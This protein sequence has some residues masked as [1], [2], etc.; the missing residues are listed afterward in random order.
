MKRI[1]K[2]AFLNP[3][4][5]VY[6]LS[7]PMISRIPVSCIML[8]LEQIFHSIHVPVFSMQLSLAKDGTVVYASFEKKSANYNS[9][10]ESKQ[11]ES[12]A[13]LKKLSSLVVD[14]KNLPT[15]TVAEFCDIVV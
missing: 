15:V 10:R 5:C 7:V 13:L 14:C 12:N 3:A 8:I 1:V 6:L 4:Y 2:W 11:R 9:M